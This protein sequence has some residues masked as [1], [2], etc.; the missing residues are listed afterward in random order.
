MQSRWYLGMLCL[1]LGGCEVSESPLLGTSVDPII[2]GSTE[3]RPGSE[4]VV[5]LNGC[6][7]V[8]VNHHTVITVEH[9]LP[10]EPVAP[11]EEPA[12]RVR[13]A[14]RGGANGDRCVTAGCEPAELEIIRQPASDLVALRSAARLGG[15]DAAALPVVRADLAP[16]AGHAHGYGVSESRTLGTR[17]S[18]PVELA[19]YSPDYIYGRT[20][21]GVRICGGD[22]GGPLFSEPVSRGAP[23][24]LLGI[25][26]ATQY[27]PA[28]P[29]CT[30]E[31]GIN[32]FA[33]IDPA[34]LRAAA[35]PC[36]V[37]G[38]ALDCRDGGTASVDRVALASPPVDAA[39]MLR[40]QGIELLDPATVSASRVALDNLVGVATDQGDF[41]AR[42]PALPASPVPGDVGIEGEGVTGEL[43]P[44]S[45][46]G[47]SLS[48]NGD[49]RVRKFVR[50]SGG[51]RST[52]STAIPSCTATLIGRRLVR[53]AKHCIEQVARP[54]FTARYDG[55]P[56]TWTFD[57][58]ATW[59]TFNPR[60][61]DFH[62]Y[63]GNYFNF[64]CQG[65][66]TNPGCHNEDWAILVMAQNVWQPVH[67]IPAFMGYAMTKTGTVTNS[68]YPSCSAMSNPNLPS[69]T[70]GLMY[71]MTC[72]V[73]V[74]N[75]AHYYSNCDTSPGQSGGGTFYTSGGVRYL[76]GNHRGG[77]SNVGCPN[78][79]CT[80]VDTGTNAWLFDFQTQLRNTH[81]AV[82]L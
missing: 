57:G 4:A 47:L 50:E 61:A 8:L 32:R 73:K 34:F 62:W 46:R 30:A 7:G 40:A 69:C 24:A 33:R 36:V 81:S 64:N 76:I 3:L 9:C 59:V 1:A 12:D 23:V 16:P 70:T 29:A 31:A 77:P 13:L 60:Q 74:N 82:T 65:A 22:S 63:G 78:G 55:G 72:S 26:S 79:T 6:S 42:L 66:F 38:A 27:D 67:V 41:L 11:G 53:T 43:V 25:L 10:L 52:S 17:F 44:L 39:A 75:G 71:G 15:V 49:Q 51:L 18:A 37:S 54:W 56:T 14:I 5:F 35:G 45:S 80:T 68:G 58:G 19:Q 28:D 20:P 2:G 48:G 21:A